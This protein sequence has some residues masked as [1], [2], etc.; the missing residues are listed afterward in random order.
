MRLGVPLV[1]LFALLA[2]FGP[3][4]AP[5]DPRAI[6]LAHAYAAPSAAHWLGTGDN[7]VDMLSVLLHG[8][9]LA[10]VVGLLVVGFTATLGT[11]VGALAGYAGGRVDHALSGLADL[12]QAFPGLILNVAILALVDAPGVRHV[13]LALCIPGWVLYARIARAEA[14]RLRDAEFVQ[15]A[16]A[17]G[18]T[19]SRVLLRHVVPNL[20]GPIVVQATTAFGGVV[21]AE[22]TLSFLGLGPSDGVSWGALLDQ[23]SAVL[24][25]FPHVALVSGAA[26]AATVL[27]F[28]L[29]GDAA[30][31]RWG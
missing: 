25:R 31:D 13:V 22:S 5:Y 26:I 27:G 4:L 18:A 28:N 23:G 8:A 24:L 19:P 3:W 7:G 9:R 2:L 21:L 15:A 6:D 14:L 30:R 12:L 11:V 1:V 29:A 20:L 16:V 10:G 17:L